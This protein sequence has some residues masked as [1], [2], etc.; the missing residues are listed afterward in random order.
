[1]SGNVPKEIED[2]YRAAQEAHR[3]AAAD[4]LTRIKAR[5]SVEPAQWELE[6]AASAR[7]VNARQ[8]LWDAIRSALGP[9]RTRHH[10]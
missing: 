3:A 4:V 10:A 7:L 2:E 5:K 6:E 9:G 1:M 8:A